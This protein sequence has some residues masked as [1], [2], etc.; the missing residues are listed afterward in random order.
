MRNLSL[1][2]I[3]LGLLNSEDALSAKDVPLTIGTTKGLCASALA[4]A[5]NALN[6]E[7]VG[8]RIETGRPRGPVSDRTNIRPTKGFLSPFV[9]VTH[10]DSTYG[11]YNTG[12][13]EFG[14][15][16]PSFAKYTIGKFDGVIHELTPILHGQITVGTIITKAEGDGPAI[17]SLLLLRL[18]NEDGK[19][20]PLANESGNTDMLNFSVYGDHRNI[21]VRTHLGSSTLYYT[22]GSSTYAVMDLTNEGLKPLKVG[23]LEHPQQGTVQIKDFHPLDGN[24]GFISYKFKNPKGPVDLTYLAPFELKNHE[25]GEFVVDWQKAV[26]ISKVQNGVELGSKKS[27]EQPLH[28]G[29]NPFSG[30]IYVLHSS[31]YRVLRF[32]PKDNRIAVLM[33]DSTLPKEL[34]GRVTEINFY[35][36]VL[37][38]T[39][40]GD[41]QIDTKAMF[42][43]ERPEGKGTQVIWADAGHDPF[44]YTPANRA[45][46][47]MSERPDKDTTLI[48]HDADPETDVDGTDEG[49][50][51]G[52][53][54]DGTGTDNS[55]SSSGND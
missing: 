46:A 48:D 24:T 33:E 26:A 31:T 35:S 23:S 12:K 7:R 17:A 30:D 53:S 37:G 34:P 19:L 51:A 11:V 8:L 44:L 55:A 28:V 3:T 25:T 21:R 27:I 52:D 20:E 15:G 47:E 14:F 29:V 13:S 50:G 45:E 42:V 5:A 38:R 39:E 49:P 16:Q 6:G 41:L 36:D 32:D 18:V 43:V 22:D 2:L 9:F 1:I 10:G 54:D 40:N 4:R